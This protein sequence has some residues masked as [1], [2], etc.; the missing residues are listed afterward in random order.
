LHIHTCLSPCADLEMSPRSIMKEAQKRGLHF[1]GICD[2]N[3]GENVSAAKKAGERERICVIGGMEV[4]SREE[5]HILALFDDACELEALQQVV[6]MNLPGTNDGRMYGDQVVVNEDDEVIDF[7]KKLLIGA[8]EIPLCEIVELIHR[9]K[10]LA[11]ASHIDR[12][13]FGII[14]QL[15]FI[16]ED[17]CL[18]AVEFTAPLQRDRVS[19]TKD[20]PMVVSSDAHFLKEIGR[21]RTRFLLKEITVDELGKSFRGEAGRRVIT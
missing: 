3:S 6:Y 14:G 21:N 13:G 7:N 8:T 2:H 5:V 20:F 12:E 9:L 15:G 19:L 1:V 11:I 4:T 18:D 16:P 10:G 17:L